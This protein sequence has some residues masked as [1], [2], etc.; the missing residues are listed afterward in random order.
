MPGARCK[1]FLLGLHTEE[2]PPDQTG[3]DNF[4]LPVRTV[5]N[6]ELNSALDL[7]VGFRK[8]FGISTRGVC[9]LKPG[10]AWMPSSSIPGTILNTGFPVYTEVYSIPRGKRRIPNKQKKLRASC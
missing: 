4:W 7:S 10:R 5:L 9:D 8:Y 1:E 2:S 3:I 6:L